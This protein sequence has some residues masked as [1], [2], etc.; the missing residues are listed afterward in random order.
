MEYALK[1]ED[2]IVKN[3]PDRDTIPS[4]LQN[5]FDFAHK[6]ARDTVM[7][8]KYG[9]ALDA[10]IKDAKIKGFALKQRVEITTTNKHSM[11]PDTKLKISPTRKQTRDF[12]ITS[13]R[14]IEPDTASFVVPAAFHKSD[15]RQ[16]DPQAPKIHMLSLE[17]A[18]K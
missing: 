2:Q 7:K 10:V 12:L 1:K 6:Q 15:P 13:I 3:M 16:A 5:T 4:E 18:G 17:P 11:A 14:R 8:T 9:P